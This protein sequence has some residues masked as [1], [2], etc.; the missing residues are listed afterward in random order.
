MLTMDK[1]DTRAVLVGALLGAA[2]GSLL[3]LLYRRAARQRQ[4]QG[5]R[6]LPPGKVV[7]LGMSLVPVFRQLLDLLS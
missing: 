2:S 7:R 1:E 6:P 3:A 5:A 4:L